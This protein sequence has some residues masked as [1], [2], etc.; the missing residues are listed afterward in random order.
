MEEDADDEGEIKLRVGSVAEG[1]DQQ[2]LVT[3]GPFSSRR[4]GMSVL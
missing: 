1:A 2:E 3:L 4:L